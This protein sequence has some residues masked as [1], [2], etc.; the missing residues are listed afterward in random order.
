M[1]RPCVRDSDEGATVRESC[2]LCYI[3]YFSWRSWDNSRKISMRNFWMSAPR[4]PTS[5]TTP[6]SCI[7]I[8]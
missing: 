2:C 1:E 3:A 4:P 5:Q 7:P 6:S 8:A